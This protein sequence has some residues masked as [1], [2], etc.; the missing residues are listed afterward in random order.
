MNRNSRASGALGSLA[1]TLVLA[2]CGVPDGNARPPLSATATDHGSA[3]PELPVPAGRNEDTGMTVAEA[4][5]RY[6]ESGRGEVPWATVVRCRIGGEQVAR[7]DP[8]TADR[9][10]AWEGCL[11]KTTTY[12][13]RECPVSPLRTIAGLDRTG[14]EVVYDSRPPE[15]VGCNRYPASMRTTR[16]IWV[17]PDE[18]HRDCFSD[19]AVTLSLNESGRLVAVDLALSGP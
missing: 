19:F 8:D 1:L 2:A 3:T 6:A 15:F 18:G 9:P 7:L 4:F 12:E 14:G 16:S 11:R 17:R 13:G 10:E 5:T